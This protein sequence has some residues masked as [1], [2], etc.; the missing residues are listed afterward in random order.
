MASQKWS[1]RDILSICGTGTEWILEEDPDL[2]TSAPKPQLLP[3]PF[4]PLVMPLSTHA[5]HWHLAIAH[6][7]HRHLARGLIC[8][9]AS[10]QHLVYPGATGH[11]TVHQLY[12]GLLLHRLCHGG[13]Y[14]PA[15]EIS[16]L[17]VGLDLPYINALFEQSPL[18]LWFCLW[19]MVEWSGQNKYF[20]IF[21]LSRMNQ[22]KGTI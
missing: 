19:A 3:E 1:P 8:P 12:Y 13:I 6:A 21:S 17:S 22:N 18:S 16:S 2:P 11:W 14:C 4:Q 20:N 10:T 15:A 9:G 5:C 7:C